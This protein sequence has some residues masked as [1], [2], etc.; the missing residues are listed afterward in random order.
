MGSQVLAW[1]T[2]FLMRVYVPKERRPS[3]CLTPETSGHRTGMRGLEMKRQLHGLLRRQSRL[4]LEAVRPVLGLEV[5]SVPF[6]EAV[7]L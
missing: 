5:S 3:G 7:V 1:G 6:G 2:C 4:H